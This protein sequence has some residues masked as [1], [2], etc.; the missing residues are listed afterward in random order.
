MQVA[1]LPAESS[2]VVYVTAVAPTGKLAPEEGP[3]VCL[4]ATLHEAS[5]AVGG[6]HATATVLPLDTVPSVTVD[7]DLVTL[8]GQTISGGVACQGL[9]DGR[10]S[11]LRY[12]SRGRI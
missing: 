4:I 12:M 1:A 3:P 6:S 2:V 9:A 10:F 5:V 8:A 7:N 11:T